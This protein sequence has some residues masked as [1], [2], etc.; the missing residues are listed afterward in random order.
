MDFSA[1]GTFFERTFSFDENSP[2]LFTQFYFWAFFAIVYAIFS[3]IAN[4]QHMRNA[5]LFFVSLFFY[6]KTSGLFVL[7]LIFVTLSDF[8][9]AQRVHRANSPLKKRI[10]LITSVTIDLFLLCY[11]KYAYFLT[12]V[13]NNIFGTNLQVYDMFAAVGNTLTGSDMF[14]V[15]QIVLPVGISFF[16]FQVI[17]YTMD[18]YK[19]KIKPVTNILDF[20]FYVTFFPQLVAGPIVRASEFIPQLYKKFFL[21][22]RQFGI[23]VFWILNGLIKKI[24]LSDY[25][26]VNFIDRVFDNPLL[27]TGFENFA[28]L[29]GYSLQVY[30]DFSGYTDIAIG[31]AMLMGFYLPTNFK[32]PYKAQ[33]ASNF[34]KRWHISLSKWLQTYLYIPLGGNRT[35]SFGTYFWIILISLIALILSGSLWAT[36]IILGIAAVVIYS[37]RRYPDRRKKI[38]SNLNRFITMLLGGIW[39]GASWNFMIWGGLNGIGML[40]YLYWRDIT[41]ERRIMILTATLAL[42]LTCVLATHAPVFNMLFVW[43]SVVAV[44]SVV[45]FAYHKIGGKRPF[46]HVASTWA[47]AQ[48]F[49]FIT[50]TRLFFRSGSN[51]DPAT[52]NETAWNTAKNMVN[53]IGSAWNIDVIPNII[54]EYKSVFLLIVI[55]MIVHWLPE[56]FKRHYRLAFASLPIPA[57]IG[58]CVLTVFVIY[59]FITADLQAFIYFQF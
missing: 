34:W 25:I 1:L 20:G 27:F 57:I 55:G 26:A 11:F 32:S 53:Q 29:F 28:A 12:D 52:A 43:L 50:F 24:V 39:H 51:L 59:Q 40:I 16:T 48:T 2:L 22:R 31:L 4:R 3:R 9:I 42:L 19:G 8:F 21:S 18:V 58:A 23:A 5:Y 41:W 7:I 44:G 6:Y 13:V 35:S 54:A 15:D 45:R 56:R 17:S 38:T 14:R 10:W 36:A 37:A 49:V 47:I 46:A 30:A 33:N